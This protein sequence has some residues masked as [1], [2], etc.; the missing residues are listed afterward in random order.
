MSQQT[1]IS[2][3]TILDAIGSDILAIGSM[4]KV[5]HILWPAMT[6]DSAASKLRSCLNPDQ[7]HKLD[8]EEVLLIK[9]KAR[10]VGS[11]ETVDFED[12]YLSKRSEWLAPEDEADRLR[13][14]FISG[15]G[16]LKTILTKIE[17]LEVRAPEL[18]LRPVR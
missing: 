2:D 4:K 14:D 5:G 8:P 15:V 10:E 12:Q 18:R 9:L 17:S 16:E 3:R 6:V 11:H 7:L 1:D 13:R